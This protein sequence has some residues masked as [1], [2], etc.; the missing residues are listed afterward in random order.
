MLLLYHLAILIIAAI[1]DLIICAFTKKKYFRF[2]PM[3][4]V[5]AGTIQKLR[6]TYIIGTFALFAFDYFFSSALESD[7]SLEFL[8]LAEFFIILIHL[9]I[10]GTIYRTSSTHG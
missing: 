8:L 9:F 6:E 5:Q 1:F 10:S 2:F 3:L 7:V 4:V